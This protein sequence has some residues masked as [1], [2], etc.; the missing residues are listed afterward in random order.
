MAAAILFNFDTLILKILHKSPCPSSKGFYVC[1][2]I[3]IDK[4][5]LC[6]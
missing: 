6:Y 2:N 1:L 5:S 4:K 3:V